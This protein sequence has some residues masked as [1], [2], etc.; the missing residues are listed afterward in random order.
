M[1]ASR[2]EGRSLNSQ[3]RIVEKEKQMEDDW[4][5]AREYRTI[6]DLP[7]TDEHKRIALVW[8]AGVIRDRL[9]V[10]KLG[11]DGHS[12]SFDPL[13]FS[14][15]GSKVHSY[16]FDLHDGGRHHSFTSFADIEARVIDETADAI[17]RDCNIE[18]K[19]DRP[20]GL[21]AGEK[22]VA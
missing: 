7:F 20:R 3:E 21:S 18:V 13:S 22:P 5:Q 14:D 16:V 9:A 1:T 17:G 11:V 4:I 2:L 15:D 6:D 12:K 19:L 10:E 8:M